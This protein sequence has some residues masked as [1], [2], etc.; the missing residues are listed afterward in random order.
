MAIIEFTDVCCGQP[1]LRVEV[2][3]PRL[4]WSYL[5]RRAER[6]MWAR[7]ARLPEH[8]MRDAGFDPEQVYDAVPGRWEER[9]PGRLRVR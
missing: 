8:L 6:R 3:L 7:V 1:S 9:H 5:R 4:I 2:G